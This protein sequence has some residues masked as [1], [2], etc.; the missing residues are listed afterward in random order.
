[1]PVTADGIQA[2]IG[3]LTADLERFMPWRAR[4]QEAVYLNKLQ[5]SFLA[6]RVF[7][8]WIGYNIAERPH[9]AFERRTADKACLEPT[10]LSKAA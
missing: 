8:S 1:V 2:R 7:D 9:R 6:K 5:D 3:S 4:K 10:K